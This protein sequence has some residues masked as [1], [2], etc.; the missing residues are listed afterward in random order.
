M[1]FKHLKFDNC[2]LGKFKIMPKIHKLK[3]GTRPIIASI[4]H[5]TSSLCFVL[6]Y[7]LQP[8]VV[9]NET[10][11]RDSQNLIQYCE[12][13]KLDDVNDLEIGTADF[14]SLYTNMD[15]EKVIEK[16]C[17]FLESIK[18][19]NDHIDI[20]GIKTFLSLVFLNNIFKY[21]NRFL[22]QV[23]GIA[24]GCICGPTVA[25]FYLY[26][27][28]RIWYRINR[29][30]VYKRF[31]DDIVYLNKG[32]LN[33]N[34]LNNQF[35]GLKLNYLTD[36]KVPFLDLYVEIDTLKKKIKFNLY[37]KPTNTFQ[38]LHINSNHPKHIFKNVPK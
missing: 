36:K 25:N 35:D 32:K 16:I 26:I 18:Y 13:I 34:D 9:K 10:Y 15:S 4:D 24:M 37:T 29:P 1:L 2:K 5:P 27:L 38:Y 30:L 12:D 20:Y 11:L 19:K 17:G 21:E 28:E 22:I 3:F 8:L 6:D 7:I 31:I 23:I 14:E 33:Q